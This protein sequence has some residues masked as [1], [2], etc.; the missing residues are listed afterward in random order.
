MIAEILI[1]KTEGNEEKKG[2]IRLP[3]GR[4]KENWCQLT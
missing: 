1:F 2:N 3:G 4:R